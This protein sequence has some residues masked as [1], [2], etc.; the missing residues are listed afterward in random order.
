MSH[1]ALDKCVR[2]RLYRLRSR[3]LACGVYDGRR[4]FLG[5]RTKFGSRY[6]FTEYHWDHPPHATAKPVEDM[7]L[8]VP[9][10]MLLNEY[11]PGTWDE[12]TDREVEFTTPVAKGG[13]GWVFKDSGEAEG[14]KIRPCGKGNFALFQWLEPFDK[15][16][17]EG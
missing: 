8:D 3:N 10:D 17:R 4:G 13:K 11:L 14:C 6:V 15:S 1:L 12:G 2:G 16:E 5:I 9:E 7:G